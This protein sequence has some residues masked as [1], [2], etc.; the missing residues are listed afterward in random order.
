MRMKCLYFLLLL[1]LKWNE[2]QS[3][4][5]LQI[6]KAKVKSITRTGV[7]SLKLC[8]HI[9][10]KEMKIKC[11]YLK[12]QKETQR[13]LI[14][15]SKYSNLAGWLTVRPEHRK[16]LIKFTRLFGAKKSSPKFSLIKTEIACLSLDATSLDVVKMLVQMNRIMRLQ[17]RSIEF[18]KLLSGTEEFLL[19]KAD[20]GLLSP[21]LVSMAKRNLQILKM[22]LTGH[23]RQVMESSVKLLRSSFMMLNSTKTDDKIKTVFDAN[24]DRVIGMLRLS[25]RRLARDIL[26]DLLKILQIYQ[27]LQSY[28]RFLRGIR[29][30]LRRMLTVA[31]VCQ[32]FPAFCSF[33]RKNIFS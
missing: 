7:P 18:Q 9:C 14:S 28:D 29:R 19:L 2:I 22:R 12:Y 10:I 31:T 33:F 27:Q 21:K 17:Q 30:P 13:C 5:P 8:I 23:Q 16:S 26:L 1:L 25:Q 24:F 6:N 15:E 20:R 32:D 4:T 11:Q 3:G